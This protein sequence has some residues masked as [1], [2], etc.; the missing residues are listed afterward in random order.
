MGRR[1][2]KEFTFYVFTFVHSKN[3][4]RFF[5]DQREMIDRVNDD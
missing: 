1:T 2:E 5:D 3:R 4:R